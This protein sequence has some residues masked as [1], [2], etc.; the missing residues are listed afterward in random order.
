MPKTSSKVRK[1]PLFPHWNSNT[2]AQGNLAFDVSQWES[3]TE[4]SSS[5]DESEIID[6]AI[7]SSSSDD[8]L[9]ENQ[10]IQPYQHEP[11]ATSS[12]SLTMRMNAHLYFY[13]LSLRNGLDPF[14]K[15]TCRLYLNY[16]DFFRSSFW[17]FGYN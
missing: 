6:E 1:Y 10:T 14:I 4:M 2:F 15:F 13:I 9:D 11:D 12:D 3:N 17:I 8:G 16:G 5:S 7:A